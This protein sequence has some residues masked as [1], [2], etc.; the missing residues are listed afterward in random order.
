MFATD[1]CASIRIFILQHSPNSL[2]GESLTVDIWFMLKETSCRRLG[3]WSWNRNEWVNIVRRIWFVS[4]KY[5]QN[6]FE[7]I[8][9]WQNVSNNIYPFDPIL[10]PHKTKIT[11][12]AMHGIRAVFLWARPCNKTDSERLFNVRRICRMASNSPSVSGLCSK[13]HHVLRVITRTVILVT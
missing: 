1:P 5:K 6:A 4:H 9:E 10:T 12:H 8:V 11:S 3:R 7:C 2:H 13:K